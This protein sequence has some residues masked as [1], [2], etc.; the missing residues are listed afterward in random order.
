MAI[1]TSFKFTNTTATTDKAVALYDMKELHAYTKAID[2][3]GK[4]WYD[5]KTATSESSEII[6][7]RGKYIDHVN[8]DLKLPDD[9]KKIQKG[10]QYAIQIEDNLV[11]EDSSI[12]FRQDDPIVM[13]LTVN[14]PNSQYITDS[15]LGTVFQRLCS[16]LQDESGNWRFADLRRLGFVLTEE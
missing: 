6:K 10:V 7:F 15:V 4:V 8:T 16:E 14:H 13:Y 2:E 12:G 11:S 3:P 9:S 1:T 5:N